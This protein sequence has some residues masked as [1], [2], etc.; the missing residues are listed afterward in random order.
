MPRRK[1]RLPYQKVGW[2]PCKD[3]CESLPG[4]KL[5]K[6]PSKKGRLAFQNRL[7][8]AQGQTE[9]TSGCAQTVEPNEILADTSSCGELI[10]S[11]GGQSERQARRFQPNK[12]K[13]SRAVERTSSLMISFGLFF[14]GEWRVHRSMKLKLVLAAGKPWSLHAPGTFFIIFS[15]LGRREHND[16]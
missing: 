5:Q 16:M 7:P 13:T 1:K 4:R 3:R 8:A 10:E 11:G 2:V 15:I 9:R 14:G 6:E 12:G